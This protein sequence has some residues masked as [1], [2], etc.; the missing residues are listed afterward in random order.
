MTVQQEIG[1]EKDH[2]QH[3]ALDEHAG[4][5]GTESTPDVIHAGNT[6]IQERIHFPS[7]P[8]STARFD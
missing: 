7:S 6:G 3:A 2:N 1:N 4:G 5:M 8:Q